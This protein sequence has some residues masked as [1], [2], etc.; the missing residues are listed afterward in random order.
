MVIFVE[1]KGTVANKFD[2]KIVGFGRV[3]FEV[4][5]DKFKTDDILITDST[6][7]NFLAIM[8]K[9]KGIITERGGILSHSA[10]I[11]REF[12]IPCIVGVK[13]ILDFVDDKYLNIVMVTDGT[14]IID[15]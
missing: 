3:I 4:D 9:S 15:E 12:N 7:P 8:L 13:G 10:I 11:S 2:K 1:I 14:V 5:S 6:N